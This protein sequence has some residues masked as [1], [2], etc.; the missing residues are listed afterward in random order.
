MRPKVTF[1]NYVYTLKVTQ[2]IRWLAI[3]LLL[4]FHVRPANQP[5]V[6]EYR[7]QPFAIKRLEFH[8]VKVPRTA[9]NGVIT[10][11][12][13]LSIIQICNFISCSTWVWKLIPRPTGRTYRRSFRGHT[14]GECLDPWYGV[15]RWWRKLHN[16]HP[17]NEASSTQMKMA[18]FMQNVNQEMKW[19]DPVGD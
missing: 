17:H 13:H 14:R 5:T 15:R 8:H 4:F 19:N 6:Q 16:K 18:Y 10:R 7:V 12:K 2:W 1:E 3:L 9:F 11:R